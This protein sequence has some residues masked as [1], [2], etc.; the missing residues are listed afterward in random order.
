MKWFLQFLSIG[1]VVIYT[2][3]I[4]I[5]KRIPDSAVENAIVSEAQSNQRR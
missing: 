5:D 3:L 4:I 2:F 1:S